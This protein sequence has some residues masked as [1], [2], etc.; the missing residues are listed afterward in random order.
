MEKI[1]HAMMELIASEVCGKSIHKSR[2]SFTDE[3][4]AKLY[5]LSKSKLQYQIGHF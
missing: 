5:K 2:Y 1:I 4:L 3:E